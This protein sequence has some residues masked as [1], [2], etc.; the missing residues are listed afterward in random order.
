[1]LGLKRGKVKLT[2]HKDQWDIEADRTI[3]ELKKLLPGL[4]IDIQHIGS[5]A[6]PSIRAKAIIDIVVALEDVSDI[7]DYIGTLEDHGYFY[8][9]EDVHKQVLFVRGDLD[10]DYR[11]HH[12]HIVN[13]G[14]DE[15]KNYINFRD[16]LNTFPEKAALYGNLKESLAKKYPDDRASYTRGK[17]GLISKLLK[18]ADQW[19]SKEKD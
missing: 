2:G 9:G 6:I 18:E 7:K 19:R 5:T 10:K 8:R 17:Q 4:A 14:S 3:K 16:Y 15:W 12:I 11:T 13:W 1:M